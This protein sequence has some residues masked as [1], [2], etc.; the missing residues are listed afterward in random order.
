MIRDHAKAVMG[1]PLVNVSTDAML[2]VLRE[3]SLAL[4]GEAEVWDVVVQWAQCTCGVVSPNP[5]AW[6]ETEVE[7]VRETI[8]P[9]LER[10]YFPAISTQR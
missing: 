6:N 9:L 2:V 1:H 7:K 8:T 5:L 3:E 4:D 10:V